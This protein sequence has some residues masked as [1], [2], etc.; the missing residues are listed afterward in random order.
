MGVRRARA[1]RHHCAGSGGRRVARAE[2]RAAVDDA[3]RHERADGARLAAGVADMSAPEPMSI[4]GASLAIYREAPTLHGL[5][6][7]ALGA[8]ECDTA[9]RGAKLI[10]EAM[11]RLKA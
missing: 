7:A 2:D 6:T 11:G 8:F 1:W 9:E 4:P 10:R 5:R 3:R